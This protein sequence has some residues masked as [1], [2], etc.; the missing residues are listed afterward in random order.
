MHAAP[1][2]ALAVLAL[3]AGAI[4]GHIEEHHHSA[5]YK[6]AY[7]VHDPHHGDVKSQHESGHGGQ[8]KGSYSLVEPDG[9]VRKVEYTADKHSGFQA[10][11]HRDGKTTRHGYGDHDTNAL[12][13]GYGAGSGYGAGYG[14]G[15]DAGHV[16]VHGASYGYH[17]PHA[18]A[19]VSIGNHY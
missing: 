18:K 15:H 13:A 10:V 19:S 2:A 4:A 5:P 16:S 11:V 3:A 12:G 6:F 1:L 17:I 8:V 9:H 7:E 14:A